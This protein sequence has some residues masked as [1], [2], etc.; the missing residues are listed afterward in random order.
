MA[1]LKFTLIRDNQVDILGIS[2]EIDARFGMRVTLIFPCLL[3]LQRVICW[4]P[5]RAGWR[6]PRNAC[7]RTR[8]G[9]R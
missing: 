7:T 3:P 9:V 1:F 5:R 4:D 6:V 2:G 8:M